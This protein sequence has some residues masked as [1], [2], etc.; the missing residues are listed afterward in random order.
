[1]DIVMNVSFISLLSLIFT[2]IF[3]L[4]IKNG[5]EIALRVSTETFNKAVVVIKGKQDADDCEKHLQVFEEKVVVLENRYEDTREF[6]H[7]Q[8]ILLIR[9]DARTENLEKQVS[10]FLS[11]SKNLQN[12]KEL[13]NLLLKE[14]NNLNN[15]GIIPGG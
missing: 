10:S 6:L 5:K 14:L 9:V 12:T 7:K 3:I 1:M 2:G 11:E 8:E 13:L 15:N 4:L